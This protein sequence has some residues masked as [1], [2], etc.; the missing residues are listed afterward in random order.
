MNSLICRVRK[1][2]ESSDFSGSDIDDIMDSVMGRKA[3]SEQKP[4]SDTPTSTGIVQLF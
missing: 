2:S 4:R 1:K 3:V